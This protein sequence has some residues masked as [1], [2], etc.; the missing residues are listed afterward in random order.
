M[1]RHPALT[2]P[3]ALDALLDG[4]VAAGW[5]RPIDRAVADFLRTHAP[6]GS[7][8]ATMAAVLASHQ[9]GGGHVCLNLA[10][11]LANP[12]FTLRMPPAEPLGPAMPEV[13]TPAAVFTALDL[14]DWR[15]AL[16]DHPAI[17]TL[18]WTRDRANTDGRPLVLVNDARPQLYLRRYWQ[19]EGRVADGLADRDVPDRPGAETVRRALDA[20]YPPSDDHVGVDWQ[21]IACALAAHQPFSI[22]TGGPG[23]GKTTTVVRLLAALTSL[24]LGDDEADR[25][26]RIALCAPTGKA[27]A[28]LSESI[29]DKLRE[30][31]SID[32][33]GF[34]EGHWSAVTARLP[35]EVHTIHRLIGTRPLAD[36]PRHHRDNP[37]D[38]DIVVVDEASMV[39]M[40]LMSRLVDA[41]PDDCRLVLLGDKDQLASVEAGAVLGELCHGAENA[42]YPA[43]LRSYLEAASGETLPESDSKQTDPIDAR[44]AML[45]VSHRFGEKSAIGRLARAVND[46]DVTAAAEALGGPESSAPTREL[47]WLLDDPGQ[48]Q[49]SAFSAQVLDGLRPWLSLIAAR[50]SGFDPD[51]S[52]DQSAIAD[53]FKRHNDF[54]VLCALRRGDAG[55]EGLNARI[56]D[57]L[58]RDGLLP[59][60]EPGARHAGWYPGRPVMVTRNDPQLGLANGDMG[61]TLPVRLDEG[62][63]GLRVVFPADPG[64]ERPFRWISPTRLPEVETAFALTVHKSQGSEF[65]RVAMVMPE[66]PNPILTRELLYTAITRARRQ[67]ALVS[68]IRTDREPSHRA[69]DVLTR[70]V[71]GVTRRSGNLRRRLLHRLAAGGAN[72]SVRPDQPLG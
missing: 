52:Q 1:S 56:H 61:L 55:V 72:S 18:D 63:V 6:G 48:P 19:V 42:A 3:I 40:E 65:T 35:D 70:A 26:P 47:D 11:V 13:D 60:P 62:D 45:R 14:D 57:W 46:G 34:P 4:W 54:Q 43:D 28:R 9:G 33:G 71:T 66:R 31:A 21:K 25:P 58:A 69:A 15:R 59:A 22:I 53:L 44:I 2:D 5:L 8:L 20:L 38:L 27:A 49:D 51:S 41:L 23:T 17:G 37:L 50:S 30:I 67:F 68:T 32:A 36:R 29:G 7:P 39:G 12:D 64:D 24:H 10:E 16:T